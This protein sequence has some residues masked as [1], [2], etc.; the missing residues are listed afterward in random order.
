[1]MTLLRKR[2]LPGLHSLFAAPVVFCRPAPWAR[3][4]DFSATLKPSG[5]NA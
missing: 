2:V 4:S 1:M 3:L 5:Q